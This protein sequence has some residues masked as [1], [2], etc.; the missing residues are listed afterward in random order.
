[1]LN[2]E[3]EKAGSKITQATEYHNNSQLG[4]DTTVHD[5]KESKKSGP[6]AYIL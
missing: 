4:V 3:Y 2:Q 1:M 6:H 5:L